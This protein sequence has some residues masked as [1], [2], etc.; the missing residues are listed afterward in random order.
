[1]Y[2]LKRLVFDH[3]I[4]LCGKTDRPQHP[5]RIV[6]EGDLRF[7]RSPDDFIPNIR[8]T[9]KGIEQ[10]P[11]PVAV[12]ADGQGVDGKVPSFLVIL[13]GPVL[14]ERFAAFPLV[15][16]PT[17]PHKFKVDVV[18]LEHCCPKV[19]KNGNFKSWTQGCCYFGREFNP[20]T[21]SNNINIIMFPFSIHD[22][23]ADETSNDIGFNTLNV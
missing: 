11:K 13:K 16:F 6:G 18:E 2:C 14:N 15:R 5:Q 20:T 7:Q 3:K 19:F 17:C 12:Q 21:N 22:Q 8:Y 4:E 10:L 23:V 9:I 1:M